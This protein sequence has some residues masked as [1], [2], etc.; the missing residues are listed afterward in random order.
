[1][2][3]HFGQSYQIDRA[4]GFVAR[5]FGAKRLAE[6]MNTHGIP[7]AVVGNHFTTVISADTFQKWRDLKAAW[8]ERDKDS[9]HL[10]VTGRSG[11]VSDA[12]K[13]RVDALCNQEKALLQ[14]A[15]VA[16]IL[17]S[18]NEQS[19]QLTLHAD[20]SGRPEQELA[21]IKAILAAQTSPSAE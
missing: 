14:E 11:E 18:F 19:G 9:L 20:S 12:E 10:R 8:T 13:Q 7:A 4:Q 3:L 17:L 21:E 2:K 16:P 15:E 6:V 1:M 5:V